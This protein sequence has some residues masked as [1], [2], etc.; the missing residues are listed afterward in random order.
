MKMNTSGFRVVVYRNVERNERDADADRVVNAESQVQAASMVLRALGGGYADYVGVSAA[1]A[2]AIQTDGNG[3]LDE[4]CYMY[5]H[6][7][8]GEFS[9]DVRL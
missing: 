6:S 9:Y 3:F 4:T 7:F 2:A 1:D 5:C 8:A